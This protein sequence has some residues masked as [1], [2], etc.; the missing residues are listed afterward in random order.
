LIVHGFHYDDVENWCTKHSIWLAT[1]ATGK[2]K[3][4]EGG[5]RKTNKQT[6]NKKKELTQ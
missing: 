2:G 1:A 5:R 6:N 3:E 4:R